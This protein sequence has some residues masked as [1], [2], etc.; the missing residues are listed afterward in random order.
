MIY[1]IGFLTEEVFITRENLRLFS[2]RIGR[3]LVYLSW[4]SFGGGYRIHR[5]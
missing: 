5:R 4:S 2:L 3:R 1:D